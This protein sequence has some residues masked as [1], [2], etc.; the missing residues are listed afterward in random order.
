MTIFFTILKKSELT[1]SKLTKIQATCATMGKK[2]SKETE[3]KTTKK[4]GITH[5]LKGKENESSQVLLLL[6]LRDSESSRKTRYWANQYLSKKILII[7][8]I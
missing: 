7:K 6:E 5:H 3:T 2:S 8:K 4:W 1:H